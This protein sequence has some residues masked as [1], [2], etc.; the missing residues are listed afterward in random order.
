M[1]KIISILNHKGGVGK[2]TTAVNLGVSLSKE[3]RVLLIDLDSQANLTSHLGFS[4]SK[5]NIYTALRGECALP[6]LNYRQN[7]D[8]V[9]SH[10]DLSAAD[11][12]FLSAIGREFLLKNLIEKYLDDYEYIV[13]DCAPSLGLLTI[14]ALAV[15][16]LVII[17]VELSFFALSGMAKLIEIF[18]MFKDKVN[19]DLKDYKILATRTD[20]RKTA[21]K[22]ILFEIKQAYPNN[23]FETFIRTNVKIEESQINRTDIF[24]YDPGSAGAEDYTC[25]CKEIINLM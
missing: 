16:N 19:K 7:I 21:H 2:T 4:P 18:G 6:I 17:P 14:N 10:I 11:M 8:V 25:L 5:E 20:L 9:C 13:I 15:T 1:A 22:D 23:T 12:E 3:Y 24:S